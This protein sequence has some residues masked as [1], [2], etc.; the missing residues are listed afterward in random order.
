MI[1][2]SPSLVAVVLASLSLVACA[3]P[4]TEESGPRAAEPAAAVEAEVDAIAPKLSGSAGLAAPMG[5]RAPSEAGTDALASGA[6]VAVLT[7]GTGAPYDVLSFDFGVERVEAPVLGT[8]APVSGRL[9]PV[10]LSVRPRANASPLAAMQLTGAPIEQ[11]RLELPKSLSKPV[12]FAKFERARVTSVTTSAGESGVL[13]AAELMVE[14]ATVEKGGAAMRLGV[15]GMECLS[16]C[17][18]DLSAVDPLGPFTQTKDATTPITQGSVRVESLDVAVSKSAADV[19]GGGMTTLDRHTMTGNLDKS[20]VQAMWQAAS[21]AVAPWLKVDVSS[22]LASVFG[23]PLAATTFEACR[24]SV[25]LVRFAS[26]PAGIKQ[27]IR[28][29]AAGLVRTDFAYDATGKLA[30]KTVAGWSFA[31]N[32]A[33][34]SCEQTA[35][36]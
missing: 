28:T 18:G 27:E 29:N 4:T 1:A 6:V 10:R 19:R 11:L 8:A 32:A 22:P 20:G 17:N 13:E 2:P 25:T 35:A 23:K 15:Q 34:T 14:S 26:S 7:L 33:I 24:T 21:G 36:L 9:L 30:G 31:Q 12:P 16:E 3:A 5:L